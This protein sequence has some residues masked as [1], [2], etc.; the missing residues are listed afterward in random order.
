MPPRATHTY[1]KT[2][3]LSGRLLQFSLREE[4]GRLRAQ[5]ADARAGRS[6]KTLVKEGAIRVTLVALT[7]GT[8]LQTHQVAGA[9]TPGRNGARTI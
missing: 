3:Q 4:D 2:H 1:L 8:T 5:A 7:K 6:A 9:T